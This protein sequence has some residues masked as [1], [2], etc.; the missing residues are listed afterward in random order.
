M[1]K[2]LNS[3]NKLKMPK[4]NESQEMNEIIWGLNNEDEPMR[5]RVRNTGGL[6]GMKKSI[7]HQD[8]SES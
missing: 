2:K 7:L 5:P 6:V 4:R 1:V 3:V 8:K